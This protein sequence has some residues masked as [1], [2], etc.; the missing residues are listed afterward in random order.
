MSTERNDYDSL[1]EEHYERV[2]RS[3]RRNQ[4]RKNQKKR[5]QVDFRSYRDTRNIDTESENENTTDTDDQNT[6]D[7]DNM[8]ND[9]AVTVSAQTDVLKSLIPNPKDFGGNREEFSE[10]WRSMTLFLKYN[11]VTDTDQKIIATIVRLKGPVPSCFADIWTEKIA[12]NFTYTWDTFEEELKTSFGKGNEKDIAEERIESLKQGNRNTMDFLVKFTA[13]MYKAK[14]DDQHAIFLLK[15]HTRHDIIKTILGYP[16][17]ETMKRIDQK[18]DTGITYGGSGQPME[19]GWKKFEWD[20]DGKPKCHKC[21]KFGHIGKNCE[22]KR[23]NFG[24]KKN[25]KCFSCGKFGH[26]AK[27]C[28][29]NRSGRIRATRILTTKTTPKR[30]RVFPMV[31]RVQ[32]LEVKPLLTTTNGK[33]LKLSAMVDSGCTHTCID[34]ELVKKKKIPT[35]KLERPITCRNS[36]GTIAGKKDITKFVKM[37]LNIN[38]HNEQLDAVVT[39]L[40]SSDL[41]LGHDWLTNHNPEIDWKQGIIK[42]NRCPT[43]CS[44][45]HTDISFEPRIRRLQS[46]EDTEEKEPDPT[47]PEDL[48]A[49]MKPFAHLFNKKNFDKLPERTE[50]DH[51]INFMENAPTEISSKVYSMTPLEREELD[52]FLDE[53]LAT[54]RIRPS[55]SPYAAPCFFVP[56]KDGSLRLCQDYRKLN[57]ITIKDKTPLPLISEVLDQL[58]DAKV[59][60]KL[61]IIWGYNNVRIREGDEWKAAFLTNRGLFE[62]TVMFFGMSNS[63]ATFSR[64]MATIFREM[65][66]EGSLA[67]YMDDFIIPAKDDEELE[68]RTIRFLKIAEKHNLSFKRTK[69]E[70]NVSSTTVLGTVIGNGKA[71]MEEEK[72]KAIRDWAVPTTVKQVE[73][74]LGF[75]NFYRRF[76]KNFSTIAQPLNELKSKKGEK[77]YWNDEQQQAF[78]QEKSNKLSPVNQS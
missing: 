19:I 61:D 8:S 17:L 12:T 16:R 32:E 7:N 52:K 15:R 35:K 39:P 46:N 56:K 77:W 20:K 63:P 58:K 70:F 27:D 10:W 59:F 29:S 53:N 41:F 69:C 2:T 44:F 1:D 72:V 78:E 28:R 38:G 14:I 18:T 51:E 5:H 33:K 9:A 75:A 42:F 71:T 50:W 67:N 30:S 43:S 45:P 64:M 24:E 40:Q 62:P 54:N 22:E 11:K 4:N 6:R 65:I 73:S 57:D 13:L 36:D 47:N 37:D 31:P 76:I 48:P 55:K 74:F 60:N 68:A 23:K 3:T 66:Q 34:E 21:G 49:Y 26:I 25:F